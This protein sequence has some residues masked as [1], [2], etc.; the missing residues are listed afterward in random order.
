M[1]VLNVHDLIAD[2]I[3]RL[4]DVNERMTAVTVFLEAK[5]AQ[6]VGDTLEDVLLGREKAELAFL[7]GMHRRVRILHNGGQGRVGHGETA[8]TTTVEL[9]NESAQGVGVSLKVDEITPLLNSKFILEFQAFTLTEVGSDGLFARVSKRRI[10]QIVRQ[11]GSRDN[12]AD[13]AQFL[14][15]RLT[16]VSRHESDDHL[17][18]HRLAHTRH[19]QAVGQA[20]VHK[21]AV[22]QRE[23]LR[24]VLQSP[25]GGREHQAVIVALKIAAHPTL[26]IV[27]MFQT[28]SLVRDQSVPIHSLNS[29][30]LLFLHKGKL[31]CPFKQKNHMSILGQGPHLLFLM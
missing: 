3:G 5:D 30:C 15:P 22:G 10:T 25:E 16:L 28:Q 11:T 24:F 8:R 9:M 31:F 27:V 29:H 23:H 2:V 21:D 13:V 14:G 19:F 18:R 1:T 7:T 6:L 12:F 4:D 17:A 26:L 20:V